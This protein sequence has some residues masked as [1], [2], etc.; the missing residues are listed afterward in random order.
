MVKSHIGHLPASKNNEFAYLYAPL[1]R[2]LANIDTFCH[3]LTGSLYAKEL[4]YREVI[5]DRWQ[6]NAL[7]GQFI[8]AQGN[9][10]GEKRHP[11]ASAL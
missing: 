1:I 9:A 7:Q 8:S 3:E 4:S 10:L 6:R 5:I 2:P 11:P